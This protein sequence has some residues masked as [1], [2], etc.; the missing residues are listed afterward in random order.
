MTTRVNERSV[1]AKWPRP[2]S[3]LLVP[4]AGA[5][6]KARVA[7]LSR[8]T[9]YTLAGSFDSSTKSFAYA[10]NK[11]NYKNNTKGFRALMTIAHLGCIEDNHN[12]G[13]CGYSTEESRGEACRES[14]VVLE[15]R[16]G[17]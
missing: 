15:R 16:P 4:W 1:H 11:L 17:I 6:M 9:V 13:S 10:T 5:S 3:Y 14:Q 12:W 8:A 2:W 7:R